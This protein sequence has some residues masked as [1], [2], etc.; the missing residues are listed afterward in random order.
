MEEQV[1][2]QSFYT[3]FNYLCA[4]VYQDSFQLQWA[5]VGGRNNEIFLERILLSLTVTCLSKSVPLRF[6]SM[7]STHLARCTHFAHKLDSRLLFG[8]QAYRPTVA[9]LIY[10]CWGRRGEGGFYLSRTDVLQAQGLKQ[11]LR[12]KQI[13]YLW[14]FSYLDVLNCL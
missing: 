7:S 11:E 2:F 13:Q 10:F 8:N 4:L 3:L 14:S 12:Q 5:I 1:P 6:D 9:T